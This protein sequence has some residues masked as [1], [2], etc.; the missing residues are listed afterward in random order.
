MKKSN[1]GYTL[2]ELSISMGILS[3]V[4]LL[5]W[6]VINTSNQAA[7]MTNAN[8]AVQ[9][10]LRDCFGAIS[11]EVRQAYSERVVDSDMAPDDVTAISVSDDGSSITFQIPQPSETE[12]VPVASQPITIAWVNEDLS[13]PTDPGFAKLDPGEDA[14]GDG[15][16]ARRLVRTQGNDSRILGA[17][18][19]LSNVLFELVPSA[20]TA[21]DRLT[22]LRITLQSA[23]R[24]GPDVRWG[25]DEEQNG[26]A[27]AQSEMVSSIHL[28]N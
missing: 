15:V 1:K 14:D 27:L 4:S 5:G 18:N 2:V 12:P 8:A 17:S 19:D 16:L 11:A 20:N 3:I 24:F 13:L 26:Q 22:T 10:N 23:K 28:E 6:V 21:S 9:S 25:A 7:Q